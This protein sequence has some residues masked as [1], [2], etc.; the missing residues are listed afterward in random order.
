[1]NLKNTKLIFRRELSDQWRDRRTLFTIVVMPLVLYPL[2]GMALLQTAQFMRQDPAR[3]LWIGQE[4]LP[5]RP[6]LLVNGQL[7]PRLQAEGR[8]DSLVLL[9]PD[10]MDSE[11]NL[12]LSGLLTGDRG[13]PDNRRLQQFMRRGQYDLLVHCSRPDPASPADSQPVLIEMIANSASDQSALA[14][15]RVTQIVDRW[16]SIALRDKLIE[17]Q[18]NPEQLAGI[19]LTT[20]DIAS[21]STRKAAMWAKLLPFIVL[22][23]ALTGAFYPAIDLCAGEK[24]RG[25][26]ETLL[27]SPARRSEI[28]AGKLLTVTTFSMA[29]ALLNLLSM[30]VTGLFVMGQLSAAAGSSLPVEMG[31]PPLT[32]HPLADRGFAADF[33]IVQL[34]GPGAGLVCPQFARG[35]V[36]SGAVADVAVAVDDAVDVARGPS[37]SGDQPDSGYRNAAAVAQPDAG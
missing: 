6:P 12:M 4:N 26:L 28:V 37:G 17:L 1:M 23:W 20:T 5:A 22:I 2:M 32:R 31:F 35:P 18:V 8:E 19:Q 33:R 24:E 21:S 15:T 9:T 11:M 30:T 34:A 27:S 29:T 36:L 14:V 10:S 25:T 16:R 13:Q 7:P 3:V